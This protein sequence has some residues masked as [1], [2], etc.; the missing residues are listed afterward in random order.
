[1]DNIFRDPSWSIR[2]ENCNVLEEN[3]NE[4]DCYQI[5][6]HKENTG[7]LKDIAIESSNK[8]E[9]HRWVVGQL[10]MV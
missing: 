6:D 9:E 2:D 8:N 7:E 10:Q 3:Y 1:M 4:W 5:R